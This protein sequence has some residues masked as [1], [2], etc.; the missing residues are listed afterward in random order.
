MFLEAVFS[1]S[2]LKVNVLK[3]KKHCNR[4]A[5]WIPADRSKNFQKKTKNASL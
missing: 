2:K 5:E 4:V 3:E 1:A